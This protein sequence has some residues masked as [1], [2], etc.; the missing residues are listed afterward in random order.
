MKS[1]HSITKIF[2]SGFSM[3][4]LHYLI[5]FIL[6]IYVAICFGKIASKNGRNPILWGII[7]VITPVNIIILGYWAF[8]GKKKKHSY[9]AAAKKKAKK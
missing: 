2:Q 4:P 9:K 7:S 1:I 3:Q 8:T 6:I 5:I